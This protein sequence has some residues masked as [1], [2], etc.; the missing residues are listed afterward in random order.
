MREGWRDPLAPPSLGCP[1]QGCLQL[2]GPALGFRPEAPVC[3]CGFEEGWDGGWAFLLSPISDYWSNPSSTELYPWKS[4]SA[5]SPQHPKLVK[6]GRPEGVHQSPSS[7]SVSFW[8]PGEREPEQS[9]YDW[10]RGG[11]DLGR[12]ISVWPTTATCPCAALGQNLSWGK[13]GQP[14][15]GVALGVATAYPY[16]GC[17]CGCSLT[18]PHGPAHIHG[19]APEASGQRDSGWT[20]VPPGLLHSAQLWLLL[21]EE[22]KGWRIGKGKGGLWTAM[23]SSHPVMSLH[24]KFT[25]TIVCVLVGTNS[26]QNS[27]VTAAPLDPLPSVVAKANFCSVQWEVRCPEGPT[28]ITWVYHFCEPLLVWKKSKLQ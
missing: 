14:A 6:L 3:P 12:G 23:S 10:A 17:P 28:E 21:L 1:L 24:S 8:A 11:G 5:R 18:C 13:S 19:A 15:S 2:V 16:W 26:F 4:K 20:W 22:R 27:S 25:R 9:S 7:W